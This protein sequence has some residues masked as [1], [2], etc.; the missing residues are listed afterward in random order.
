[1]LR[2]PRS[3]GSGSRCCDIRR[4]RRVKA[5]ILIA[6][7]VGAEAEQEFVYVAHPEGRRPSANCGPSRMPARPRSAIPHWDAR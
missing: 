2:M 7:D 1:M 5:G 3:P 4:R 6:I